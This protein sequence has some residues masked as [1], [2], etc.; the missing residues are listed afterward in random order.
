MYLERLSYLFDDESIKEDFINNIMKKVLI[1]I[2]YNK[3]IYT[4]VNIYN[5]EDNRVNNV[6]FVDDSDNVELILCVETK[7]QHRF[8]TTLKDEYAVD[9][10]KTIFNDFECIDS[11]HFHEIA[12]F[13]KAYR[14]YMKELFGEQ[15]EEDCKTYIRRKAEEK[16]YYEA[17]DE[18]KTTLEEN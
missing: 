4:Y 1:E 13:N 9:E 18:I 7:C 6:A 10:G 3:G 5:S 2:P 15:Y 16:A 8:I 17:E 11:Y 12:E 14:S